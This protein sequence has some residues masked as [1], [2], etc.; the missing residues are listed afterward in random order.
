VPPGEDPIV[1]A[2][3]EVPEDEIQWEQNLSMGYPYVFGALTSEY[4]QAE[5]RS[6]YAIRSGNA[7]AGN[8]LATAYDDWTEIEFVQEGAII[9]GIGGDNSNWSYGTFYEGAMTA[10]R[11]T[12][13]TDQ[14]V[15]ANVQA[16]GYG[17]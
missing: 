16:A 11:P 1:L 4:V 9:L 5:G 12:L 17:P 14:A 6:H 10:G 3:T 7:E 15:Y 13:A 8:T 2:G